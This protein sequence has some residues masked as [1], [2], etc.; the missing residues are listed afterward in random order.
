M[1][2]DL[3]IK[4]EKMLEIFIVIKRLIMVIII[5]V[6]EYVMVLC[7]VVLVMCELIKMLSKVVVNIIIYF[8]S[9][10]LMLVVKLLKL[11]VM[12]NVINI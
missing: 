7:S 6:W 1:I 2:Y 9:C 4:I 3:L 11:V 10:I 5:F 12:S 8:G